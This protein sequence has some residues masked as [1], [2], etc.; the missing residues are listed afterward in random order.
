VTGATSTTGAGT[1][2]G[3]ASAGCYLADGDNKDFEGVTLTAIAASR[4]GGFL[5]RNHAES[6]GAVTVSTAATLADFPLPVGSELQFT[7]ADCLGTLQTVTVEPLSTALVSII[8]TGA[9]A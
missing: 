1:D 8:S 3:V 2:A 4:L 9:T 7:S 6:P 5:I